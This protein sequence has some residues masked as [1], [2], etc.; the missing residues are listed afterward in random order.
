MGRKQHRT[1]AKAW[2]PL[3][4]AV[5]SFDQTNG[6]VDLSEGES[7]SE[8]HEFDESDLIARG[9]ASNAATMGWSGGF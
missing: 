2:V 6:V 3:G 4:D 8:R 7:P 1:E 5:A 9:A